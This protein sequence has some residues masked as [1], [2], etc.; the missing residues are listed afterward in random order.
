M[1]L[2]FVTVTEYGVLKN[3][4]VQ[5]CLQLTTIV[6]QDPKAKTM[7]L[8]N[9]DLTEQANASNVDQCKQIDPGDEVIQVN[10]QTVVG[11]QLKNLVSIMKEDPRGAR[12]TLKKH[13]QNITGNSSSIVKNVRWEPHPLEGLGATGVSR[14][15]ESVS[16]MTVDQQTQ[17]EQER[18]FHSPLPGQH[19]PR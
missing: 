10:D 2:P 1:R 17:V 12:V 19:R 18:F 3:K 14:P 15:T 11:W 4:I 6:Q 13:P 16:T 7:D 5:L 8:W 9:K